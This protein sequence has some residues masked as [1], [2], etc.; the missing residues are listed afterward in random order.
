MTRKER[1][2]AVIAALLEEQA[3]E[4]DRGESVLTIEIKRNDGGYPRAAR[5][6]KAPYW[7]DVSEALLQTR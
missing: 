4:D 2:L 1:L 6:F 7:R 5:I 3:V